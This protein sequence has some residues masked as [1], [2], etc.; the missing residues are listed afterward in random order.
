M[1]IAAPTGRQRGVCLRMIG[2]KGADLIEPGNT[3]ASFEA[4][5]KAGVDMIELDVLWR[6]D[7]HPK[8]PAS[9]RTPLVVAH[10]WQDAERRRPLTLDEA[11]EAFT[12][13]PLDRVELDCDLK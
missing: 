1:E 13:P 8:L 10:D 2:D 12:R 6:R 3:L 5:V 7:G 11:L 4:A 9:E